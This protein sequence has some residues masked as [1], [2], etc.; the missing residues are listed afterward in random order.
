MLSVGPHWSWRH[1]RGAQYFVGVDVV[2][3]LDAM[4][5][6]LFALD[7]GDDPR[8]ADFTA[9]RLT[10]VRVSRFGESWTVRLDALG[11][12]SPHVLPYGER[13]KIGGDRLGRG[14]EVA[15]I[16]G[17]SGLGAKVEL[18][19]S[20][21]NAPAVLSG[22]ALYGF[23]DLGAAFKHDVPGRESAA[24]AGFGLAI[25]RNRV[26]STIELAKPLTHP[27]VEGRKDVARTAYESPRARPRRDL[28]RRLARWRLLERNRRP[29][30]RP[31]P[32]YRA[33]ARCC[34][35]DRRATLP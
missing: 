28:P 24:T 3:G 18:R 25:G 35:S 12:Q 13:F 5:S 26:S 6:G 14:F 2:Q 9:T 4:G 16:A 7:L 17:D 15:E 19:R 8:R 33:S 22:A 34:S 20:L 23:Y 29:R 30:H 10:F 31:L 11:Q 1:E 21:A 32:T 27:D